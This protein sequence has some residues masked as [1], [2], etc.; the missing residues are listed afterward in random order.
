MTIVI[1]SNFLFA[2]KSTQDKNHQRSFEILKDLRDNYKNSFITSICVVNET[3]TLTIAR[4]KGNIHYLENMSKLFWG[5]DNFFKVFPLTPEE[6]KDV[7]EILIKY[8]N[9]KRF[10][11]FVDASLIFLYEK[12]NAEY[13]LSFDRHFEFIAERKF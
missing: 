2:L 12:Y 6:Y 4:Y 3:L 13:I 5:E 8:C 7:Y 10:L 1:D 9:P 11:S